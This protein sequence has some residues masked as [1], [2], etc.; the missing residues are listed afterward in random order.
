M[1]PDA[2]RAPGVAPKLAHQIPA[3]KSDHIVSRDECLA[4][5]SNPCSYSNCLMPT[6]RAD[7]DVAVAAV[8]RWADQ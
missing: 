8:L 7:F 4:A 6:T 5:C 2:E 3:K 1:T